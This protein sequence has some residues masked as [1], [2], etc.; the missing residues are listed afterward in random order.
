MSTPTPASSPDGTTAGSTSTQVSGGAETAPTA[1]AGAPGAVIGGRY[2]L[3]TPI[4]SGGMGTV[5]RAR[6]ELLRRHIAIKEVLLPPGI[7]P[8]EREAMYER[9]LR[10]ARAAAGL[11]HPSVVRVYDVVT[12]SDRPWIVMELLQARSLA[13]I[14][15]DDGPLPARALAKVGLS[16]LG[17]LEA[18]H[19]AGVLHRDVK[20][21]NVLICSDGRCVLTDF[22]VARIKDDNAALTSPGMVLGSPQYMSPERAL[23]ASF[24]PPSDLFSL[25]VTLYAAAEGAPPF[26]RGDPL[27]TM[28]AVVYEDP[29][30]PRGAPELAPVLFGLLDKDP[31]R[32]WDV[33]RTRAALRGLLNGGGPVPQQSAGPPAITATQ[34]MPPVP[35]PV[36]GAPQSGGP[37][38]PGPVSGAPTAFLGPSSAPPA[39]PGPVM[40]PGTARVPPPAPPQQT[41]MMPAAH[42]GA[43]GWHGGQAGGRRRLGPLL[44]AGGAAVV[45]LLLVLLV[46]GAANGWFSGG[47]GQPKASGTPT[48]AFATQAYS[49]PN[50]Y[51]VEVPANWSKQP[52]NGNNVMDFVDPAHPTAKIR[53]N[54]EGAGKETPEQFLKVGGNGLDHGYPDYQQ[55]SLGDQGQLGGRQAS[56]LEYELTDPS[57]KEKHHGLWRACV[58]DGKAFEVYLSVPVDQFAA[59]KPVFDHAVQS[60]KFN[61]G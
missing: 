24:G 1:S 10:E 42:A 3:D 5:W 38:G 36:S 6:D 8:D 46:V 40:Q 34:A 22:G 55:V 27:S 35:P 48:P 53:L 60:F 21:A 41:G 23:G 50:G 13:D 17:A 12:D 25:G 37:A 33:E 7:P 52:G 20:P 44:F 28:H 9:T 54:V 47:A 49:D 14:I 26:D 30:S 32:R 31:D 43:H 19:S 16:V 56:Q 59:D 61:G 58:V 45:A 2:A 18:A 11:S 39:S 51:S 57:H 4:G 15:R 29:E